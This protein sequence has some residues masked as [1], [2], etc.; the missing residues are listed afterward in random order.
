MLLVLAV[1]ISGCGG[2]DEPPSTPAGNATDA[3]FVAGMIPHHEGAIEMA[4]LAETRAEREE[5][6]QLAD[7]ILASQQ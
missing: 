3:R 7:D 6:K 4:K 5:I 1:S 2:T